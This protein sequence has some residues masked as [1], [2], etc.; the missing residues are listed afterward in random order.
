[1][2]EQFNLRTTIA[3]PLQGVAKQLRPLAT[4]DQTYVDAYN[5][6]CSVLEGFDKKLRERTGS[7]LNKDWSSI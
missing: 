3:E 5:S 6:L 2:P 7:G 1:M 4:E